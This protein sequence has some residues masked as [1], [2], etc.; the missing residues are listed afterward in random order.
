MS[1]SQF[2]STDEGNL[3][4]FDELPD[5]H[6]FD[7]FDDRNSFFV[8]LTLPSD[9]SLASI[10]STP[11]LVSDPKQT[12]AAPAEVTR[13]EL[14]VG[15]MQ[16]IS[17]SSLPGL[18]MTIN[19]PSDIRE[20]RPL[21]DSGDTI[22][23]KRHKSNSSKDKKA[24]TAPKLPKIAQHIKYL[25]RDT[26]EMRGY[27]E[28]LNQLLTYVL[29]WAKTIRQ[30]KTGTHLNAPIVSA[31]SSYL[32]SYYR[33]SNLHHLLIHEC[34]N[35]IIIACEGYGYK[36]KDP[37]TWKER[38]IACE[39]YLKIMIPLLNKIIACMVSGKE[40]NDPVN[41]IP[42]CLTKIKT[43][44]ET[45]RFYQASTSY[46]NSNSV[47]KKVAQ[48]PPQSASHS[49][50]QKLS[51]AELAKKAL[52]DAIEME[53]KCHAELVK[54]SHAFE[55]ASA[56]RQRAFDQYQ[57]AILAENIAAGAGSSQGGLF[58]VKAQNLAFGLPPAQQLDPQ[59]S[60][61]SLYSFQLGEAI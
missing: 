44:R 48:E 32:S 39:D 59:S 19:A 13:P 27:K 42:E 3:F 16:S 25:V 12:F 22:A 53:T 55:V 4:N 56:A 30:N 14:P 50:E 45:F 61:P 5:Q 29:E 18:T 58:A 60:T 57:Q 23:T 11:H 33:P 2:N 21:Q 1:S 52:D 47:D 31:R 37:E 28:A 34:L 51:P 46:G 40:F 10:I 15:S 49:H 36:R 8:P 43:R 6:S 7:I 38:K 24:K 35:N 41:P 17:A 9:P 26:K 54:A 20:K